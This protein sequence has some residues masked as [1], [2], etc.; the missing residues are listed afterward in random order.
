MFELTSS[1]L[2]NLE[3][4]KKKYS[5]LEV[6]LQAA[7][8][9]IRMFN[10][11][12]EEDGNVY[13]INPYFHIY[14]N[15]SSEYTDELSFSRDLNNSNSAAYN[16]LARSLAK[17]FIYENTALPMIESEKIIDE[18]LFLVNVKSATEYFIQDYNATINKRIA[19]AVKEVYPSFV[20]IKKTSTR[21][22]PMESKL[23]YAF[24]ENAGTYQSL[25][26]YGSGLKLLFLERL[27]RYIET[28]K[29]YYGYKDSIRNYTP[30]FTKGETSFSN[31]F[32]SVSVFKNGNANVK[33]LNSD[34]LAK[35][36]NI[37]NTA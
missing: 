3:T 12:K 25:N 19:K 13:A 27:L 30:R 4:I 10:N 7:I 5:K 26:D 20:K 11:G 35:I 33:I 2:L 37:I 8:D 22:F 1:A 24:K 34:S 32:I 23:D 9:N 14:R 15:S 6:F 28:G 18:N 29:Y 36:D 16:L 17:A 31:Q 21:I